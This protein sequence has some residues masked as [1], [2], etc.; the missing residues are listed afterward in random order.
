MNIENH[1][2]IRDQDY[3]NEMS[4]QSWEEQTQPCPMRKGY[5]YV[6]P[7]CC[8][9]K[10]SVEDDECVLCGKPIHWKK[11]ATCMGKGEIIAR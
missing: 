1:M 4:G 8:A 10:P 11:C 3:Y 5:G 6:A 9:I 2:V 7:S